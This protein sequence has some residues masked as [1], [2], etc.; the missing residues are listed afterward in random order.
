MKQNFTI[1]TVALMA[2]VALTTAT[3]TLADYQKT[4]VYGRN[5]G[6][7]IIG[8]D[9]RE[10]VEWNSVTGKKIVRLLDGGERFRCT[11]TVIGP[12]LI[13]TAAHCVHQNNRWLEGNRA[14]TY[15]ETWDGNL[16]HIKTRRVL[17]NWHG[18]TDDGDAIDSSE[19]AY[20]VGLI[21]TTDE[22]AGR[23]GIMRVIPPESGLDQPA[24]VK[25]VAFHGD[26]D[27]QRGS[28]LVSETCLAQFGTF[29]IPLDVWRVPHQCD[30]TGGSSGGPLLIGVGNGEKAVAAISVAV[31]FSWWHDIGAQNTGVRVDEQDGFVRK[32]IRKN[33]A[34]HDREE[35]EGR[36]VPAW[37]Q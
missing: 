18:M 30:A 4:L 17:G 3:P 20:D 34:D 37:Q 12:S 16:A 10:P 23:T 31:G 6:H 29:I 24:A 36:R 9:D 21:W 19:F 33:F 35:P 28:R 32:W 27:R 11:G 5:P 14:I 7:G 8:L 22:I 1:A 15:V 25:L 26:I 2:T 13:L